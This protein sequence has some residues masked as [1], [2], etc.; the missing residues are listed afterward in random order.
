M[1]IFISWFDE[2]SQAV[3]DA[4]GDWIPSVIQA[5]ETSVAS[6][7]IRKGTKWLQEVTTELSQSSST[8][9]CIISSNL[10]DPWLNF[11]MGVLS[12]SLDMSKVIPLFIGAERSE[13]D[14]GPLARFSS[15]VFDKND[16]YQ[17]MEMINAS[18][19]KGK[20][21]KGRLRNTFDVWWPKL[22]QDVESVEEEESDSVQ[23]A[24]NPESAPEPAPEPVTEPAVETA[25]EPAPE[26]ERNSKTVEKQGAAVPVQ[27]EPAKS[28]KQESVKPV[29]Q[30]A[31][32][33]AKQEPVKPIKLVS[34]KPPLEDMEIDILRMLDETAENTPR[35]AA[36]VGYKFDITAQNATEFLEKLE[37]ENYVRE[38]LFIGRPKEYSVAPK[39]REYLTKKDVA[40][41]RKG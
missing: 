26:P 21:T 2:K 19:G 35:T 24:E 20:I 40:N 30:E 18:V 9:L 8:I 34:P 6:E 15:A 17:M 29:K 22:V 38:H 41:Q 32:K 4:L 13:L 28:A 33:P 1:K 37:R 39:G 27:Q 36:E 3:A 23:Q 7:D 12:T 5:V 14:D 16:I 11:E 25:P 10:G 31:V